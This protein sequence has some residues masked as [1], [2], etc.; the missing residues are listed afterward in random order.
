MNSRQ[1]IIPFPNSAVT[2][3][4][5]DETIPKTL[6]HLI[7]LA[8]EQRLKTIIESEN[9][10]ELVRLL[11]KQ[12]FYITVKELGA[13]VS[14]PLLE[15]ASHDQ[16]T[17]LFDL[18]WWDSQTIDIEKVCKWLE[19]LREKAPRQLLVWLSHVDAELLVVLLK[20]W[21]IIERIPEDVDY[22]EASDKLPPYTLD[23]VFY[24]NTRKAEDLPLLKAIISTLFEM[25]QVRYFQILES[26]IWALPSEFEENAL[27]MRRGRLEDQAIPDFD[28]AV[29]IYR[30]LEL[31][32]FRNIS[33]TKGNHHLALND[34]TPSSYP[35]VL[36]PK[37]C[38]LARV[39]EKI[40]DSN[41]LDFLKI[42]FAALANKI[43]IADRLPLGQSESFKEATS[44]TVAYVQVGL[45]LLDCKTIHALYKIL[46]MYP[47]ESLF[48]LG[49]T[50]VRSLK[51]RARK[52]L[53]EGW[54]N[55][56]KHGIE[57]LPPGY[58][59]IV[60]WLLE[61]QPKCLRR[62]T[63]EKGQITHFS[64][65]EDVLWTEDKLDDIESWGDLYDGLSLDYKII[66]ESLWEN[67]Q[68][69]E[70]RD[71]II[72]HFILTAAA[73]IF[74][75][76]HPLY[77]PI[78]KKKIP[79]VLR[80]FTTSTQKIIAD[81]NNNFAFSSENSKRRNLIYCEDI[82]NQFKLGISQLTNIDEIYPG[83]IE[84][85]LIKTG[86]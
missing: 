5:H 67:G 21:L 63:D 24:W 43:I 60:I 22:V 27:R 86:N 69:G 15:L 37:S 17:F 18:E 56:W 55:N 14:S 33:V 72:D 80:E 64:N 53:Q 13:L 78:P 74:L 35:L 44:K 48:R 10:R 57:I 38:A 42:E 32:E 25:D 83:Y 85:L 19:L 66:E 3:Q 31:K 76:R 36:L 2:A 40:N 46:E 51:L 12:D 70:M 29:E 73:N 81:F 7:Y 58:K 45:D 20:K 23:N 65:I 41:L 79:H 54:I 30:A 68:P 28:D 26:V 16:L 82:I 75:H 84:G 6:N 77:L 11:P 61:S 8:P 39:L 71:I 52:I 9:S 4:A 59:D 47:L 62:L 1:N 50:Q 49:F 34:L